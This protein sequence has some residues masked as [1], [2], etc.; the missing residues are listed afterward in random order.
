MQW[1]DLGETDTGRSGP[2]CCRTFLDLAAS[3]NLSRRPLSGCDLD[4]TAPVWDDSTFM[5]G[6]TFSG[7]RLHCAQG[8]DHRRQRAPSQ[9]NTRQADCSP[10]DVRPG[11]GATG[12]RH[13]RP[14]VTAR[15]LFSTSVRQMVQSAPLPS[16][17]RPRTI[18]TTRTQACPHQRQEMIKRI[19][20][21]RF[22]R[23]SD[24]ACLR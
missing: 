17:T 11:A 20:Y 21:R 15:G 2:G 24:E 9:V 23:L 10:K 14:Y 16:T 3:K 12:P 18:S 13:A 5:P 4:P 19:L 8:P 6:A 22:R 1:P 7:R